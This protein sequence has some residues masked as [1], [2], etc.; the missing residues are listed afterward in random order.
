FVFFS[1]DNG[2]Q[3][4]GGNPPSFFA[5]SGPLRGIKRDLYEGGIRIP[6]IARW[7]GKIKAGAVSEQIGAFWDFLPTMAE[8]TGAKPPE[9]L[10]GISLLPAL[11]EG[12]IVA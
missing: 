5:S 12:K 10:D 7:P 11:I 3:K 1:S 2:P 8:L 6:A 4:Q 9:N